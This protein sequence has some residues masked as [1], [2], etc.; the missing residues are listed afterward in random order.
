MTSL[1]S[2]LVQQF[3]SF[4]VNAVEEIPSDL[5]H[6]CKDTFTLEVD[7]LADLM[8]NAAVQEKLQEDILGPKLEGG[9][10]TR[11]CWVVEADSIP[12]VKKNITSGGER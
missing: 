4:T 3:K 10:N 5:E 11:E 8:Q 2:P 9:Y 12:V 1:R 6:D 7:Q